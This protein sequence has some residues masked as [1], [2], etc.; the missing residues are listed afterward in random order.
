MT[1]QQQQKFSI[2]SLE[3][4]DF[5]KFDHRIFNFAEDLT[6][7]VGENGSGKSAILEALALSFQVKDR[8]ASVHQYIRHGK[9]SSTIRLNCIWLGKPLLIEST[10]A[11]VG[12]RRIH[13]VVTYDGKSFEDTQANNYLL[14]FFDNKSLVVAFALQGN[15]KFLT[16]SKSANLKNL[17]NLLQLDFSKEVWY[18]KEKLQSFEKEKTQELNELNRQQGA[19][20]TLESSLTQA[21]Q[22][23]EDLQSQLKEALEETPLDVA[24]IDAQLFDLKNSLQQL[25]QIK[26]TTETNLA[27]WNT[28]KSSLETNERE[29]ARVE[30]QL[31]SLLVIERLQSKE[32]ELQHISQIE[33]TL[34]ELQASLK[35]ATADCSGYENR[36]ASLKTSQKFEIDKKQQLNSGICPTC[37]QVIPKNLS[38]ALDNKLQSIEK[39]IKDLEESLKEASNKKQ[40]LEMNIVAKTNEQREVNQKL[41][42]IDRKNADIQ[43]KLSLKEQLFKSQELLQASV[44]NGKKTVEQLEAKY[45]DSAANKSQEIADLRCR[46]QTLEEQKNREKARVEKQSLL[47]SRIEDY[48][49]HIENY[50]K[51]VTTYEEQVKLKEQVVESAQKGISDWSKA[52]EIFNLLPKLHLKTFIDDIQV[53]CNSIAVEFGYK[54]M[55]IESDEKGISFI[56]QDWPLDDVEEADTPYE[57]C[58]AFEKNLINLS[59]VYA[60]SRMFRVP[61]VCID[62]LDASADAENTARLGELVK[63]ILQYTPVVTV[64]HD[65]SLVGELLQSNYKVSIL[66]TVAE[67]GEVSEGFTQQSFRS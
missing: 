65:S 48:K 36:L 33:K 13:R 37:S 5:M 7:V 3:L 4:I 11:K 58:S 30:E 66:K 20:E 40:S 9:T 41:Q 67:K 27:N 35:Q 31:K 17:V 14:E 61:F 39:Q 57:M 23:L 51:N 28:A 52:Q 47:K 22:T 45:R 12:A 19:K 6:I 60:L 54:G 24:S 38:I 18:A 55:R 64:S 16:A 56:L 21:K 63:L 44:E 2:Q 25:L 10:F 26:Q 50:E 8:G 53:V 1:I 49:K 15:E 32:E 62:E 46:I 59:L 29:L 42:E 43:H 34:L